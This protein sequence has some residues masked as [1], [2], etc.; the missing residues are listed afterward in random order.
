VQTVWE[1]ITGSTTLLCTSADLAVLGLE[2]EIRGVIREKFRSEFAADSG[3]PSRVSRL[4][5]QEL[6]STGRLSEVGF[7][8]G[9]V[10]T[11][12][13]FQLFLKHE[14]SFN[15]LIQDLTEEGIYP[16]SIRI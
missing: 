8:P 7:R 10:L 13:Q 4:L 14:H 16:L 3:L 9:D 5:V 6:L 1:G 2:E 11:V 15:K 12:F